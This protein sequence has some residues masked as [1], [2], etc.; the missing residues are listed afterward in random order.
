MLTH[1]LAHHVA[2]KS[3]QMHSGQHRLESIL[4]MLRYHPCDHPRQNVSRAARRHARIARRIHPRLAIW[5]H[6]QC[7][8]PFEHY[9]QFVIARKLPCHSQS[10]LLHLGDIASDQSRHL[11][12]MRRDHQHAAFALQFL[13]IV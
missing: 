4:R 12:R 5:L 9:D 13:C 6:N 2:G 3:V 1:A 10:I 7:A 8:I 11:A